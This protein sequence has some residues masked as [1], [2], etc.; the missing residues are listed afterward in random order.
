MKKKLISLLSIAPL[1]FSVLPGIVSCSKTDSSVFNK[2]VVSDLKNGNIQV[3]LNTDKED[4]KIT[5][6]KN[7][8]ISFRVNP[9]LKDDENKKDYYDKLSE[10]LSLVK[11]ELYDFYIPILNNDENSFVLFEIND[12]EKVEIRFSKILEYNNKKII[13]LTAEE[14]N[15]TIKDKLN[16]QKNFINDLKN[17][18]QFQLQSIYNEYK[19]TESLKPS[20]Q[21]KIL[22]FYDF[23]STDAFNAFTNQNLLTFLENKLSSYFISEFP[24]FNNSYYKNVI[25]PS[26][27]ISYEKGQVEGSY[28]FKFKLS[29]TPLDIAPEAA[30]DIS[31]TI[32]IN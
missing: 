1:S 6:L 24:F 13:N 7:E 9:S 16:K 31:I 29:T 26:A 28:T 12:G 18:L 23:L 22:S 30:Y 20:D 8:N 4:L 32:W 27:N 19:E 11:I 5:D 10:T 14:I 25:I 3:V 21:Q 15:Q 17:W 2:I